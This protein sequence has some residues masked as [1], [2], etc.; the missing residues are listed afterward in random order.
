M[1]QEARQVVQL[2]PLLLDWRRLL[3]ALIR[4]ALFVSQPHFVA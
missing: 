1:L 4:V 2:Q 3:R